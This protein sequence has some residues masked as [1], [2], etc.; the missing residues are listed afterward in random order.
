MKSLTYLERYFSD[1]AK[2]ETTGEIVVRI[3]KDKALVEFWREF[4]EKCKIKRFLE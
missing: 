1:S 3:A 2:G 4:Q